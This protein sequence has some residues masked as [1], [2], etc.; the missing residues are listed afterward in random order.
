MTD[1]PIATDE[2]GNPILNQFSSDGFVDCTFRIAAISTFEPAHRLSLV[3]SV[4]GHPVGF[5]VF[6]RRGIRSGFDPDMNL[7]REHFYEPAVQVQ[8]TGP[9]SDRFVDLLAILYGFPPAVHRMVDVLPMTGIALHQGDIDME[10]E[11]IR[12]KLFGN[13]GD[14]QVERGEYFESFFELDLPNGLVFWNE[15]DP[16]YRIP[17]I[18][19]LSAE[20]TPLR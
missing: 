6:V 11:A 20:R 18:A 7:I 15:K 3:A 13:D 4:G 9:E 16:S 5:D 17:L 2:H 1:R 12:I 19:G 8:R 10:R 14:E